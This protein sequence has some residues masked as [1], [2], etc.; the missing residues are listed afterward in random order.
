VRTRRASSGFTLV[1]LIVASTVTAMVAGSAVLVLSQVTAAQ[2][3]VAR[4]TDWQQEARAAIQSI[5]RSLRNAYRPTEQEQNRLEGRDD[6][7]AAFPGD[8]VRFFTISSRVIRPGEPQSDVHQV[9]YFLF[10]D[11]AG[12]TNLM[13][14]TDPT[15]NVEPDDGGVLERVA[16]GIVGLNMN[17]YDG[18]GWREQWIKDVPPFPV[19]VRIEV[20]A[21]SADGGAQVHQV[22]RV[23]NFPYQPGLAAQPEGEDRP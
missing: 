1:E 10:E 22:S 17:Y 3:R 16:S 14:R 15:R 8:R 6:F 5:A 13:R 20:M 9:E 11:E 12:V 7:A 18:V 4:Q 2:T 19:A 23:V 21:R